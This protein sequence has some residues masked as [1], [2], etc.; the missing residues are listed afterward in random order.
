MLDLAGYDVITMSIGKAIQVPVWHRY[1]GHYY[2]YATP[3]LFDWKRQLGRSGFYWLS[4]G[5]RLMRGGSIGW[6]A[7]NVIALARLRAVPLLHE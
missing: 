2:L 1:V 7:P 6:F 5:E 4:L 3:F